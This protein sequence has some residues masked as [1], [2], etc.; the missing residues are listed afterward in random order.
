M[1]DDSLTKKKNVELQKTFL[2]VYACDIFFSNIKKNP[3]YFQKERLYFVYF[4][5]KNIF[6]LSNTTLH[7]CT[8]SGKST[9]W[10]ICNEKTI[11][12]QNTT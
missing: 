3:L 1:L 2:S 11:L 12:S 7:M 9:E 10:C 6:N 8:Y 5:S 4:N